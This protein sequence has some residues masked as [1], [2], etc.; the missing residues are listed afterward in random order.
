MSWVGALLKY[1]NY[2]VFYKEHFFLTPP[3]C[4]LTFSWI[5]LHMLLRCCLIHI[6]IIMVG[7]VLH[8]IYLCLCL[9]LG[10]FMLYLWNL[11]SIF[12]LILKAINYIYSHKNKRTRFLDIFHNISYYLWMITWMKKANHFQIA[13][14]QPQGVA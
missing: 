14:V 9:T 13:E 11:F 10:L 1:L 6:T 2:M 5:E 3:Q 12:S 4:C 7:Y 8:L